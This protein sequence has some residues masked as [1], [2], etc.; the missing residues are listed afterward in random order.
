MKLTYLGALTGL[1]ILAGSTASATTL[2]TFLNVDNQFTAYISI[3]D[4]VQGT[5]FSSGTHWPTGN[6]GSTT[7]TD[8]VTNY[9]HIFAEDL[10]GIAALLGSF[11]L[12]DT[13]F[14][15]ANGTQSLV[16][17]DAGLTVSETGWGAYG[18]TSTIGSNG[19][20]P[21]GFRSG[22][23]PAAQWVWSNDPDGDNT[24]YFSA[25]ISYDIASV[26]LPAGLPLLAFGLGAFG[27]A[28]KRRKT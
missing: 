23:N 7:L 15:F 9:L 24:V 12:S 14:S 10:G 5:Q 16:S 4:T 26:P 28:A 17:G 1:A 13:D 20:S 8:G 18:A 2:T 3:D 21:W 19:I 11:S 25:A 27:L 6:A 22:H